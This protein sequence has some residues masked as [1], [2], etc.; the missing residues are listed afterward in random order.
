M[1]NKEKDFV[2]KPFDIYR[3]IRISQL[4]GK[5]MVKHND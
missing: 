1:N 2:I 3:D 4:R 5:D